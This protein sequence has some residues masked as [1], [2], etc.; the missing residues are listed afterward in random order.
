MKMPTEYYWKKGFKK[1]RHM[2]GIKIFLKKK[3]TKN[4]NTVASNIRTFSEEE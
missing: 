4:K 3:K 2:K 1:K